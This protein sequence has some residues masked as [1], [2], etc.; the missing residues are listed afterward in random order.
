[1][2]YNAITGNFYNVITQKWDFDPKLKELREKLHTTQY[3]YVKYTVFG[4]TLHIP[5][6]RDEHGTN[7][8]SV[9]SH[10]NWR[11]FKIDKRKLKCRKYQNE[12][13]CQLDKEVEELRTKNTVNGI[14]PSRF[15][16]LSKGRGLR[17]LT[18]DCLVI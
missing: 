6:Y 1:M 2:E 18:L 12:L 11:H 9:Y 10:Q 5:R 7:F 17:E 16:I 13:R 3:I 8:P 14:K 4:F 15:A